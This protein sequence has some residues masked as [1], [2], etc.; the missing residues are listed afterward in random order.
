MKYTLNRASL[1]GIR[2]PHDIVTTNSPVR[3]RPNKMFGNAGHGKN[4]IIIVFT[5]KLR[6]LAS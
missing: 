4:A 1:D 6:A 2:S 5:N 3:A